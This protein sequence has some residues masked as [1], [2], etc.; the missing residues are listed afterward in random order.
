MCTVSGLIRNKEIN[1]HQGRRQIV[2]N[3]LTL[4]QWACF[5]GVVGS[6]LTKDKYKVELCYYGYMMMVIIIIT[7][8]EN[9]HSNIF[10]MG[11]LQ[12]CI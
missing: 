4:G 10:G 11:K 7:Q 2:G 5:N 6:E 3:T 8:I 12:I 9:V 1:F